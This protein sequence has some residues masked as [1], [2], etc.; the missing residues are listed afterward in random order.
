MRFYVGTRVSR[1]DE[2]SSLIQFLVKRGHQVT[3]DWT[4]YPSIKPFAENI[5]KAKMLSGKGI[6]GVIEA[7]VYVLLAHH[8]GPGVFTELGAALA[9]FVL[10]G[11]SIIYAVA[12]EIP[13]AL[14]HYHPAVVWKPDVD[15]L[16]ADIDSKYPSV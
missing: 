14:F 15:A 4:K 5:D 16:L 7:D 9:S 3:F 12:K 11:T 2:A 1:M 6:L 8:D 13:E 10:R